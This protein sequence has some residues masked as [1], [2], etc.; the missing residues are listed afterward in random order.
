M[1]LC[2][3]TYNAAIICFSKTS[4]SKVHL[5]RGH[6]GPD[7]EEIYS[8]TLPSTLALAGGGWSTPHP[9]CFTPGKD[10]VPTVQEA[11]WALGPV[12]MGGENL[13]PT[14]IQSLDH[15]VR[16]ELLYRLSYPGLF[17]K[18]STDTIEYNQI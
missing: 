8:S 9:G 1:K 18:T 13:A 17:S 6:E 11:G 10:P 4:K 12:W 2:V 16:S 3:I 5:G 15:P 14:R 7:G